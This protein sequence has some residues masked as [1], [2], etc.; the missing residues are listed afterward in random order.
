MADGNR[1]RWIWIR[2]LGTGRITGIEGGVVSLTELEGDTSPSLADVV[3]VA[4]LVT[5]LTKLE[6]ITCAMTVVS[7]TEGEDSSGELVDSTDASVL[8]MLVVLGS[9]AGLVRTGGSILVDDC[10]SSGD[11][12]FTEVVD[13][14]S[15]GG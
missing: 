9:G 6:G 13:G 7:M 15:T 3:S 12:L 4:V 11:G 10:N 1:E 14:D 5:S 8:V 2:V